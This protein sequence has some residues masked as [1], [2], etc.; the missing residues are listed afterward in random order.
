MSELRIGIFGGTFDPIH[1]AHLITIEHVRQQLDLGE[2]VFVPAGQPW[3]KA[4]E[5][6]S[7]PHHRLAMTKLATASS[8]YFRVSG[9]E[10]ERTGPTYSIDT[11]RE[12]ND[13]LNNEAEL[14]LILGFDALAELPSWRE[15]EHLID[16]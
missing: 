7:A 12:Y 6:I 15:P 8:Q 14:Y 3:L 11:I 5:E 1:V 9:I 13:T 2:V 4:G 10:I 16:L